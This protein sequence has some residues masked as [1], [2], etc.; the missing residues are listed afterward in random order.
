MKRRSASCVGW[1]WTGG[2]VQVKSGGGAGASG[3]FTFQHRVAAWLATR[4]LGEASL[5]LQEIEQSTP[6]FL[7]CEAGQPVDDIVLRTRADGYVFL[8]AKAGA[9]RLSGKASSELGKAI[10][11]FVAQ[12][13]AGRPGGAALDSRRDRLVLAVGPACSQAIALS[14]P[15][16]LHRIR[17][18]PG[19]EPLTNFANSDEERRAISSVLGHVNRCWRSLA[20]M[21]P[22]NAEIRGMLSLIEIRTF[23]LDAGG[24]DEHTAKDLLRT[25]VLEDPIQADAAWDRLVTS[26]AQFTAERLGGDTGRFQALLSEAGVRLRAAPSYRQDIERVRSHSQTT[27][28]LLR[29]FSFIRQDSKEVKVRRKS[30][31]ELARTISGGSLVV[32]GEPGAGKSGALYDVSEKLLAG[33]HDVILLAADR[34]VAPSLGALRQTLGLEHEV[35]DVLRSWPGSGAGFLVIDGLD[36]ARQESAGRTL[37]DLIRLVMEQKSRWRVLASVRRFDLRHSAELQDLFR[38]EGPPVVAPELREKEFESLSHLNIPVLDDTEVAQLAEQSQALASLIGAAPLE[39]K[40]LLRV[41]FNLHLLAD[42]LNSGVPIAELVPVRSQIELLERYWKARVKLWNGSDDGLSDARE[43]VLRMAC[44]AMVESRALQVE[45]SRVARADTS[46]AL[47]QVLSSQVLQEDEIADTLKFAHH[48]LFDYAVARLLLRGPVDRLVES[49]EGDPDLIIVIRP[50]I[51]LHF[52][53]LW[54]ADPQR[55]AFWK[56]TFATIASETLPEIVKLVGP[57]VAAELG[58]SVGDF[59]ILRANSRAAEEQEAS[60]AERAVMHLM[61][62]LLAKNPDELIGTNAGPWCAL[63]EA[64]SQ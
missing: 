5:G 16:V 35:L 50:S 40:R 17:G 46:V 9:L 31:E 61:G 38:C 55:E 26:C 56:A 34:S 37:R 43:A 62:A 4:M 58:T 59:E 10:A 28:S 48:V 23:S 11:Q 53:Y 2:D 42:L 6:T 57:S 36:A 21:D 20:G 30:T 63:V 27:A 25:G 60:V 44:E 1:R 51:V 24:A 22:S 47:T 52:Q 49:L 19:E 13:R 39:L 18:Q 45:R 14:L 3:G 32:V 54:V 64:L 15:K 7:Q 12:Y 29:R 8:Q 41:P 33:G